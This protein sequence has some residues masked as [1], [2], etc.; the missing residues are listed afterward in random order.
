[1]TI[2]YISPVPVFLG[3]EVARPGRRTMPPTFGNGSRL[4]GRVRPIPGDYCIVRKRRK[5]TADV[6]FYGRLRPSPHN[7]I[8]AIRDTLE[9]PVDRGTVPWPEQ[10]RLTKVFGNAHKV[11]VHARY[12]SE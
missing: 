11:Y 5:R 7:F 9:W 12:A 6:F 4:G 2:H 1:M 8:L 3:T 10:A